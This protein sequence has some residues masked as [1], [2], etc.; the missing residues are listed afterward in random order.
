MHPCLLTPWH[1]LCTCA[2]QQHVR[3]GLTRG[4]SAHLFTAAAWC[5]LSFCPSLRPEGDAAMAQALQADQATQ[6]RAAEAAAAAAAA[7]AAEEAAATAA[8]ER[9]LQAE[10]ARAS[11]RASLPVRCPDDPHDKVCAATQAGAAHNWRLRSELGLYLA[12][13]SSAPASCPGTVASAQSG[14][15][16]HATQLESSTSASPGRQ[17]RPRLPRRSRSPARRARPP[18]LCG[19]RTRASRGGA[20]RPRPTSAP[21]TPGW[22]AWMASRAGSRARGRW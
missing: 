10:R 11:A 14:V 19:C 5:L 9:V 13:S 17:S 18:S 12:P 3:P 16:R 4:P 6:A 21:C 22:P 8:A 2:A 15:S 7:A 20:L 1:L